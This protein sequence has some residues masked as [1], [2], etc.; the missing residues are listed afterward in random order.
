MAKPVRIQSENGSYCNGCDKVV[1]PKGAPVVQVGAEPYWDSPTAYLC[2]ACVKDALDEMT[3][4][5]SPQP[6][7]G[8]DE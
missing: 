2:F 3:R 4:P 1:E 5:E 7:E 8:T 6:G